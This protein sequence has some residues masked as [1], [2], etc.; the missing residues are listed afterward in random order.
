MKKIRIKDIKDGD[1]LGRDIRSGEGR[2]L[3]K[4]GTVLDASFIERLSQ[5]SIR[6]IF[7]EGRDLPEELEHFDS[8]SLRRLE[9]SIDSR[10]EDVAEDEIMKETLRVA[11][12]LII[13]RALRR[14]EILTKSQLNLLNKLKELPSVPPLYK[15]LSQAVNDKR[16]TSQSVSRIIE[17]DAALAQKMLKLVNSPFY[18]FREK[19]SSL[20][21]A[22]PMLGFENTANLVFSLKLVELFD[23]DM[24]VV[25]EIIKDIWQHS[26]GSAIIARGIANRKG[27]KNKDE[28]YLAGLLHDIG[29]V[30]MAKYCS[31][32][33]LKVENAKLSD[34]RE[35]SSIEYDILGYTHVDAG[36][37]IAERWQLSPLIKSAIGHHHT[38]YEAKEY[39]TEVAV[40]HIANIWSHS[41]YFGG[42]KGKIA[43]VDEEAWNMVGMNLDDVEPVMMK[44]ESVFEEIE[45][46]IL[47]KPSQKNSELVVGVKRK[48]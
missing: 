39:E 20:E 40:T 7:I 30:I 47:S 33:Y 4:A 46:I 38:P 13:E 11:K 43:G 18:G 34:D 5:R 44:A 24:E 15:T 12:R 41:L 22:I 27:F 42:G 23:S 6:E 21:S 16:T 14:G 19:I 36:K 31:E 45:P 26:L 28:F 10:F 35:S 25:S 32:D 3:F 1:T 8:R 29:K 9:K 2:L 17:S 37:I 48:D